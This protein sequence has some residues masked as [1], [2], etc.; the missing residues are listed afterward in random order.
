MSEEFIITNDGAGHI[1]LPVHP[2]GPHAAV[3]IDIIDRGTVKEFNKFQNKEEMVR[4]VTLRFFC[5]QYHQ[6]EDGKQ[7]PLWI[8]KWF[9]ASM[10]EKAT[11][12]KFVGQWRGKPIS[13][14]E[15]KRF[16]LAKLLHAPA[17]LQVSHNVKPD[18]TY[19][20]IDSIMRIVPGMTVPQTP[21][22]YVR[23]K[24]RPPRD[25]NGNGNSQPN[26]MD[27]LAQQERRDSRMAGMAQGGP[28]RYDNEPPPPPP[29]ADWDDELPF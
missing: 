1:D 28:P 19:A 23:V 27:R 11:L 3:C 12:R 5:G 16:D 25:E 8:D 14:E 22:D 4:K 24:D 6:T 9:R 15:A 17:L 10:N 7:I 21:T 13:E 20:N 2:D 26:G 29:P 18:R